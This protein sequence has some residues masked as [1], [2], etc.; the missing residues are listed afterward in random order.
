VNASGRLDVDASSGS[1]VYYLG[2]PT[3]G[4]IDT[5]SGSIVEPK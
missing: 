4:E 2:D 5:S 3:L 1:K